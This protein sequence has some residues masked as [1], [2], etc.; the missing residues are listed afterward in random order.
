MSL[1]DKIKADMKYCLKN[2]ETEKLNIIRLLISEFQRKPNPHIELTDKE[3][4]SIINKM[5]K[6][7]QDL[8]KYKNEITSSFIDVLSS[9]L[10][11]QLTKDELIKELKEK[12]NDVLSLNKNDRIKKMGTILK[13]Y[14][15]S[16]DGKMLK[17]V[18]MEYV[19]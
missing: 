5:I 7:E 13:D 14:G 1:Q 8:L 12:Y 18:L 3:V 6:S 9:Y 11:K 2:K 15:P 10:P 17:D 4:I 19:G 16:I